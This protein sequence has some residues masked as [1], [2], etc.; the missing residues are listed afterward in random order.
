MKAR[1]ITGDAISDAAIGQSPYI[2][3]RRWTVGNHVK[4]KVVARKFPVI[5]RAG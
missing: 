3:P 5:F 1:F 2:M 4:D